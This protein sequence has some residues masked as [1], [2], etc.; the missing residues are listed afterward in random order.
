M[1]LLGG[2]VSVSTG[3]GLGGKFDVVGPNKWK[4]PAL[5]EMLLPADRLLRNTTC[6]KLFHNGS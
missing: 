3:G 5:S 4:Y 2:S 1:V 6:C